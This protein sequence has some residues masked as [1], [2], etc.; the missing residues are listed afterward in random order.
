LNYAKT[1]GKHLPYLSSI[2]T[3]LIKQEIFRLSKGDCPQGKDFIK[4]R[5]QNIKSES[6]KYIQI[7]KK[8]NP[9]NIRTKFEEIRDDWPQ[10]HYMLETGPYNK[11]TENISD[12]LLY[13]TP[14]KFPYINT[15]INAQLYIN[16]SVAF[17]G[18]KPD[19]YTS[20]FRHLISANTTG[21]FVT[22]DER[23]IYRYH[24]VCPY[25]N[26]VHWNDFKNKMLT[27][28]LKLSGGSLA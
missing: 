8:Q 17:K 1:G 15:Y 4:N 2:N 16:Y 25:I 9:N 18:A 11:D 27:R 10:R 24:K 19:T 22:M 7:V 26:I 23:V 6:V 13:T 12:S 20:D 5:E 3:T 21:C 28:Q 14:E